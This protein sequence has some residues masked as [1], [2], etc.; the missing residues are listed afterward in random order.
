MSNSITQI[1]VG[2]RGSKLA[3]KQAKLVIEKFKSLKKIKEKFSFKIIKIRTEGDINKSKI[4]DAGYKGFFT[5]KIDDLLLKGKIDLAVHSAKDIPS[6]IERNII[7]SAFLKREDPRDILFSKNNYSFKKLPKNIVIGTSSIRRKTQIQNLRPDLNIK[8]MRGN[9]ETRI[10]KFK[11]NNYFAI[12]LALAGVKRLGLKYKK[13][14][15]LNSSKFVP[16]GG[17]GAIAVT[18]LKKSNIINSLV[19]KINDTKTEIEV[20]TERKFLEKINADCDSPVGAYARIIKKSINFSITVPDP[21]NN[22]IYFYKSKGKINNP[23]NLGIKS[24]ANLKKELGKNFLKKN[25]LRKEISILLT[26]PKKQSNEFKSNKKFNFISNPMLEIKP[27]KLN[28]NQKEQIKYANTII[29]TSSN[30]VFFSKK[31]LKSFKN[32]VL[33]VG[34]DTKKICLKNS[35]KNVYSANGN[36]LDLIKLIEKKI[37]N[38]KEK[39]VYVSAKET[40]V[41][42][43]SILR[44]KG[45][46][47]NKVIVYEAKKI[48]VINKNILEKIKSNQLNFISFFSKKTAESFNSVVL[49]YKLREYLKNIGCISLSSEIEN[50]LKKNNFKDYYVCPS[51][52]R[53]SFLKFINQKLV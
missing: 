36:V 50:S 2:T 9:I 27:L 38:K 4:L 7:I 6:K 18:V 21:N 16:A 42:L 26:R 33:C 28:K 31:F 48:K 29:F 47:I 8:Y 52:D 51:P 17:Q 32:K 23:E 35:I 1:K 46:N 40:S 3:L 14:N 11:N 43:I 30:A 37:N 49:K 45:F 41:N 19:R 5:K 22:R 15:I 24:A 34:R 12:I 44:K 10:R 25:N 53:K 20:K 39:L 13:K